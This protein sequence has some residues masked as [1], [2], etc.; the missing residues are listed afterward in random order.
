MSRVRRMTRWAALPVLSWGLAACSASDAITTA[1]VQP[2]Q[3]VKVAEPDCAS[4]KTEIDRMNTAK[5]PE[6]LQQAAAKKYSPTPDEWSSFPRY[7]NL[8]ETYGVKKCEPSLQQ[9]GKTQA[10]AKAKTADASA[11]MKTASAPADATAKAK[12]APAKAAETTAAAAV[13]EA[14]QP[15]AAPYQGVTLQIPSAEQKQ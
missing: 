11:A 3:P 7:N 1:S 2:A 6:K 10:K 15:A 4:L 13:P 14:A 9:A 8:V 5:L 12:A